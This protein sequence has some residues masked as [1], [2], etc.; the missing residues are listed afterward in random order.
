ETPLSNGRHRG[1][2]VAESFGSY[3]AQV[4]EVSIENGQVRVHRVVCA[5]DCGLVVNPDIVV[6]QMESGIV[7]GL[8]ATLKSAI[9]IDNGRV[10]Q[11]N[12]DDFPLLR[13]SETPV[14]EVHIVPSE[15]SPGGVGEPGLPPIAPAVCNAVFAATGQP[16]RSLPI[17]L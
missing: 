8:T 17:R 10:Q 5:V 6:A 12:F 11:G 16:Q 15:E 2:A 7:F 13:M 1:I 9:S 3:V 4:A 14:I